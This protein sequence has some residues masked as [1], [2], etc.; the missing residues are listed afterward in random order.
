MWRGDRKQSLMKV[1]RKRSA[2][3]SKDKI[4]ALVSTHRGSPR[5]RAVRMVH[6][7]VFLRVGPNCD[8]IAA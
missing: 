2:K 6:S 3:V 1:K 8:Y 7:V 5:T 4:N